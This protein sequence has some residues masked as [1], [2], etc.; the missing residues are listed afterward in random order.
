MNTNKI[1]IPTNI[2]V[3]LNTKTIKTKIK[4][5]KKEN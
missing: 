1:D 3:Y 4:L 2:L 5:R